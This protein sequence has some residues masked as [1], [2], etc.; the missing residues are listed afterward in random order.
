MSRHSIPLVRSL[1]CFLVLTVGLLGW[2]IY[3]KNSLDDSS[4]QLAISTTREIFAD[5]NAERLV[6]HAHQSLLAQLSAESLHAYLIS[7]RRTLGS[8][9]A[10]EA[11]AGSS[12]VSL[13]PLSRTVPTADFE[14]S[15]IFD[16]KPAQAIVAM[17]YQ[18][19]AW[20]FTAYNIDSS[21]LY[22]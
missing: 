22:N 11:I 3:R 9:Q 14:I 10:I 12:V 21:L 1:I 7:V 2:G 5:G 13:N 8:L 4:T 15:L 18:Q 17:T 16:G 6:A 20:Q 19:G